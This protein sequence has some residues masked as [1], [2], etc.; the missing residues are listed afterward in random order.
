MAARRRIVELN[1]RRQHVRRSRTVYVNAFIRS[2]F[3]PLDV[4]SD[5]ALI[6]KYR[7]NREVIQELCALVQPQFVRTTR[8]NF[9]LSPTVQLLAALRFYASGSFFEVLGDGLGL[10]RSSISNRSRS[11]ALAAHC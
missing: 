8:H 2:T 1:D 6:C 10:S 9:A 4:L 5:E 3:S 11:G 7:L